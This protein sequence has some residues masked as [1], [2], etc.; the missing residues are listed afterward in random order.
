M[1]KNSIFFS[2]LIFNLLFLNINSLNKVEPLL[3][4][5]RSNSFIELTRQSN[6]I[7]LFTDSLREDHVSFNKFR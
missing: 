3:S 5:S 4:K 1:E 7:S 2:F 6:D